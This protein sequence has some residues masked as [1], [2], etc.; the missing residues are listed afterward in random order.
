[1]SVAFIGALSSL[2]TLETYK[3]MHW[4]AGDDFG[5]KLLQGVITGVLPP[6]LL[7]LLM[8]V[9]PFVLRRTPPVIHYK[10]NS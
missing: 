7:A 2:S 1:M 8:K 9:L 10:I 4:L 6:V 5:H 3:W